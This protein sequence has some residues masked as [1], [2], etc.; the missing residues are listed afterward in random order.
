MD[1]TWVGARLIHW[2]A[3][4]SQSEW[5]FPHKKALLQTKILLGFISCL[6]SWSRTIPQVKK[7]D[8]VVKPVGRTAKF[9][10]ITFDSA[11]GREMNLQ[12]SGY[13][14]GGHSCSQHANCMLPQ[15]ETAVAL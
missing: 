5:L 2:G 1:F 3:R 8:V 7:P 4:P 11:Y 6:G 15:L 9:S 12:F 10:K 14:S 13:S